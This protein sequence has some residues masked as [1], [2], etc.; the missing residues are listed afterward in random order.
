MRTEWGH[1]YVVP[2]LSISFG[3]IQMKFVQYFS[4]DNF[5]KEYILFDCKHKI[6]SL[7]LYL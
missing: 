6:L 7:Y 2:S 1:L 4:D 5:Y 3:V